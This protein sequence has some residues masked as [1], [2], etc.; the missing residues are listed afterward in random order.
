[1]GKGARGKSSASSATR[2]KHAAAAAA[3]RGELPPNGTPEGNPK[4][5]GPQ[6]K[7][8]SKKERKMLARKKAYVP[9]PKPP[10]PPPYPLDS[11]GL[12]SLLPA[13]LVI[14]L[15][16]GLKKD[17]IT[18]VRTLESLL[19]WIQGEASSQEET[20][21]AL[22]PSPE[23]RNEALALMLPCWAYLFP[24][25]ALSPSQRLR[26]LTLQV[27]E[28]LLTFP[29]PSED[30]TNLREELLSYT[31]MHEIL[32]YWAVL[33][34]D[35]SRTVARQGMQLWKSCTTW[36]TTE[37]TPTP[38][39][40]LLADYVDTLLEHVR[41][42]LLSDMPIAALAQMTP[43]LQVSPA[44]KD[45]GEW[46]AK[47]RDDTNVDENMDEMNGRIVAGALGLVTMLAQTP[48]GVSDESLASLAESHSMWTAFLSKEAQTEGEGPA[49]GNGTPV[50]R[51]RAWAL[52]ALLNQSYPA[53]VDEHLDVIV[54]L[55]MQGAW[56][57]RDPSVICDMQ[58]ALLPLLKRKPE[59][60]TMRDEDDDDENEGSDD[61]A[62]SS[63]TTYLAEFLHWLQVVA[64]A[65]PSK[66]FPAVLVFVSTMPESVMPRTSTAMAS[67][68]EPM[69]GLASILLHGLTDPL[70]WDAYVSMVVECLTWMSM[71]ILRSPSVDAECA[72]VTIQLLE[73]E[74]VW[75]WRTLLLSQDL[76]LPLRLRK[77]SA[78]VLA[79]DI[80]KLNHR[81]HDIWLLATLAKAMEEDVQTM[82]LDT[83]APVVL[84]FLT[85]AWSPSL[86]APW[87]E[88]ITNLVHTLTE[89]LV[90]TWSESHVE[91]LSQMLQSSWASL[92][93]QGPCADTLLVWATDV[94]PSHVAEWDNVHTIKAWYAAYLSHVADTS[95]VWHAL[96]RTTTHMPATLL[97][98]VLDL[99]TQTPPDAAT[100]EMWHDSLMDEVTTHAP[101]WRLLLDAP[102]SLHSDKTVTRLL[103]ALALNIQQGD[104][105]AQTTS[106]D[107]LGAWIEKDPARMDRLVSDETLHSLVPKLY[108]TAY[109]DET[110]MTD[111]ADTWWTRLVQSAQDPSPLYAQAVVALREALA[112]GTVPPT[113]LVRATQ[114]L[115]HTY[116]S[117]VAP[118][119]DMLAE[120]VD[121]VAQC[122][123]DPA[124]LIHD[125]L[126]PLESTAPR[127]SPEDVAKLVRMVETCIALSSSHISTPMLL[128]ALVLAAIVL[129]DTLLLNDAQVGAPLAS[130]S[131]PVWQ[132]TVQASLVR[133]IQASTRM[134]STFTSHLS[135]AWHT[136]AVT[137]LTEGQAPDDAARVL[138]ECW[139][140][141]KESGGLQ[142]ARVFA[143]LLA[144]IL[145]LS[146]ASA[147]DAEVWAKTAKSQTKAPTPLL[148]AVLYATRSYAFDTPS[149]DRWRNEL[150]AQLSSVSPACANTDG[151]RYMQMLQCATAP[152][153]SGKPIVPTQRAV[154]A[155]QT[156]QRWVASDEDLDEGVFVHL[157]A[158]C[159]ELAPV[160]QSVPGR[161]LDMMLDVVEE[162]I[163]AVTLELPT[164]WP[165]LYTTLRLLE[166]MYALRTQEHVADLLRQRA[167]GLEEA[168]CH[169]FTSACKF[170]AESTHDIN[171]LQRECCERLV[172]LVEEH[173]PAK[174]VVQEDLT[175][176]LVKLMATPTSYRSLQVAAWHTYREAT[177]ARVRDQ[178]VEMSLGSLGDKASTPAL[179]PVLMAALTHQVP[180]TADM[181]TDASPA[182][183][184]ATFS[185]LLLWL[186][187][188]DHFV[189]ASLPLRTLYASALQSQALTSTVL[190]PSVFALMNG[191]PRALDGIPALDASRFAMDDVRMEDFN[192]TSALGLQ[193]LASHV[194]FRTLV[195]LPTQVRDWWLSIRDR[196]MSLQVSHFTSK[197]CTPL[198]AER[199][200]RHLR[201][202]AALA[203]L[204]DEAMTIKVLS[205][206]EVVA[207]YTVDEHP[208]E[209]GVRLPPDYPLHG[210]EIR[211]IKRVGVSEAQ[212]R[213]WLLAVQQLL[214]GK[215]GL[216]LDALTL[217]K[218]NAEAKFQ[219][220]EGAECAICYSIIS[221][222]DQTL[223]T[224]PCR[225]CKH[226]FHGSCLYKW[227][228]TSGA[229]TCPLCRSIL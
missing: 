99:A 28:A 89:R 165:T 34:Y 68:I 142:Y 22:P 33:T 96:L 11:M 104:A 168:L 131:E 194:Y 31:Y 129:E 112:L 84:E 171:E 190:L 189:E 111:L 78:R 121:H 132:T 118:S 221:P 128:M 173:V 7:K 19:A 204:Q 13:D 159:A 56:A 174:R 115:P 65:S 49:L 182:T 87:R 175:T 205:S 153:E 154:F 21:A 224:K 114:R 12:A 212:W 158:L 181:W 98:M 146:S 81:E 203:Q 216:I 149:V 26:Q 143:R 141:A 39:K 137:T 43:S 55:A 177:M 95:P 139:A 126:V 220:Y 184:H 4:A 209:I 135:E 20:T 179:D 124:L 86:T 57:E 127:A 138:Q 70:A 82:D 63:N 197:F 229:S 147:H 207:T 69:M 103:Q 228:S 125:P 53:M 187:V 107:V 217:F 75:V 160:V 17:I 208:M 2:K 122:A 145:S 51:Q 130:P 136:H 214:S 97:P 213:A 172:A 83:I 47:S 36:T 166:T 186:A 25:L 32:G 102:P 202:P 199:E 169:A 29:P 5:K 180:V 150:A 176:K 120:L 44:S 178:V 140:Y 90:A 6:G 116:A 188:L 109:L 156:L 61:E 163:Q 152:L 46:D 110:D 105:D 193:V 108:T 16:K 134:L 148:C 91:W 37:G 101:T 76:D 123:V 40:L 106:W 92:L 183:R 58:G 162:N 151:V 64:P 77:K 200:L 222:T 73:E 23:E 30:A 215:N 8:L 45:G 1:M 79:K 88:T 223:P 198:L 27:H 3:K 117:Q 60:W 80:P 211:D 93:L 119:H 226:K 59:A 167:D 170:A 210:V 18:R 41:P 185:F 67:L 14:L 161:H 35:T 74:L 100:A 113:Q 155:L 219:G 9:P 71:R 201:D 218:K 10:Q 157:A 85:H 196:Q 15:R 38:T 195:H 52:L 72:A 62:S 225:T 54:P 50:A 192:P 42:I 133:V 48:G 144:G 94:I 206:N 191:R 66:C 24:R 164:G 227:V